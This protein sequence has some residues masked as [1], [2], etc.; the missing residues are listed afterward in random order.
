MYINNMHA[1]LRT[2]WFSASPVLNRH[3]VRDFEV[4]IPQL[5]GTL[6]EIVMCTFQSKRF[7]HNTISH[8]WI[9]QKVPNWYIYS[10]LHHK[11][12]FNAN[13]FKPFSSTIYNMTWKKK[14]MPP[15]K[16]L[17]FSQLV[18]CSENSSVPASVLTLDFAGVQIWTQFSMNSL[19][20]QMI[21]KVIKEV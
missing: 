20:K 21:Y 19:R 18:H 1:W 13:K 6:N 17:A 9:S 12:N 8:K 3:R 7:I 4:Q 5:K 14:I 10:F 11:Q 2:L 16:M 15:N